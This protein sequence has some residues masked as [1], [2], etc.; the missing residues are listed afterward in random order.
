MVGLIILLI[1]ESIREVLSKTDCNYCVI[2]KIAYCSCIDFCCFL[3]RC[4]LAKILG[5]H[6][7]YTELVLIGTTLQFPFESLEIH[8]FLTIIYCL[9]ITWNVSS[10]FLNCSS[11]IIWPATGIGKRATNDAATPNPQPPPSNTNSTASNPTTSNTTT[12]PPANTNTTTL[13]DQRQIGLHS[14]YLSLLSLLLLQ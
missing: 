6:F 7:L 2:C 8:L 12:Q 13:N 1:N 10:C 9:G 11:N 14:L 5:I 4:P 3:W